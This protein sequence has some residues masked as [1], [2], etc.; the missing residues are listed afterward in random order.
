M[1]A[2]CVIWITSAPL[3]GDD[4][5]DLLIEYRQNSYREIGTQQLL[6]TRRFITA[7][8]VLN[9]D[10]DVYG[11]YVGDVYLDEKRRILGFDSGYI[12]LNEVAGGRTESQEPH[13]GVLQTHCWVCG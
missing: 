2:T 5:T 8:L 10:G 12:Q 11:V 13:R 6:A 3:S 1:A 9:A 7:T 4:G